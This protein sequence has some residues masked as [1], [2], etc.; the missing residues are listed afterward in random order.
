VIGS[1]KAYGA[2]GK[3]PSRPTP[4]LAFEIDVVDIVKAESRR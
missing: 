1:D 3:D 2:E 4:P